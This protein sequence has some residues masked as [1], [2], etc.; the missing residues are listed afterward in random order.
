MAKETEQLLNDTLHESGKS[1]DYPAEYERLTKENQELID[2]Y[3]K[4]ATSYKK[5]REL[6]LRDFT[7]VLDN[8]MGVYIDDKERV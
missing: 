1:V 3:N 5:L 7:R 6:Y 2:N 8:E 4:L